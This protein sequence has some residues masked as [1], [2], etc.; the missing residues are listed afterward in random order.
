[1]GHANSEVTLDIYAHAMKSDEANAADVWDD[2]TAEIVDR[3]KAAPKT[4]SSGKNSAVIFGY[5]GKAKKA[6]ND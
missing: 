3:T 6:A 4:K 5:P 1:M 2:A